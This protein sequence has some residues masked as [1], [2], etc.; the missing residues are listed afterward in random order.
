MDKSAITYWYP[1]IKEIIPT[2]KTVII[3]VSIH[4]FDDTDTIGNIINIIQTIL[5]KERIRYPLF[6]KTDTYSAKWY[7]SDS[8]FVE[9]KGNLR[10][11]ILSLLSLNQDDDCRPINAL[12][13]KQYIQP[14][15]KLSAFNDMPI[16]K[17]RRY[18][19]ENKRVLC[20]HPYWEESSIEFF[21]ED[22]PEDWRDILSDLNVEDALE[23]EI[24]TRESELFATLIDDNGYFS[25]DFMQGIAG[26]WYI[27][28]C[29]EGHKSYHNDNCPV[30]LDKQ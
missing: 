18:F 16:G 30:F 10:A 27:I 2:P 8:C 4:D 13:F 26:N 25:V 17:E 7:W 24:L 21:K 6:M 20:H 11:N 23:V 3:P 1:L 22:Y 19:I 5:D 29:A 28:D 12:V 9:H 14:E 15:T